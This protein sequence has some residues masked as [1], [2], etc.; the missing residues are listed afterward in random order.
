VHVDQHVDVAGANRR[1]CR[2]V[3]P[4]ADVDHLIEGAA[5]PGAVRRAVLG[6]EVERIDPEAAAVVRLDQFGHQQADRVRAQVARQVADADR[7]VRGRAG[8]GGLAWEA[9]YFRW[10]NDSADSHC[11]AGSVEQREHGEGRRGGHERVDAQARR[12]RVHG[13]RALLLRRCTQCWMASGCIGLS[14]RLFARADSAAAYCR[15]VSCSRPT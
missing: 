11:R 1:G 6:T 4:P 10:T 2:L 12:G 3:V 9:P 15:F 13:P 8:G 14:R 5:K 7:G